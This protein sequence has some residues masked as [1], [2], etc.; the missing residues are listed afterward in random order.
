MAQVIWTE[1]ALNNL[2]AIADYIAVENPL[3]AAA[4]VQRVF[5]H[6]EQL[7]AHPESG[8]RVPELKRSRYRQIVEPPC[9]VLYRF[10][11]AKAF[12]LH[13]MRSEQL[14]RK[15]LLETRDL[16]RGL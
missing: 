8:P 15:G 14:L 7:E 12:I 4:L 11:G 10:D 3:A 6:I 5:G 16:E 9:R 1:P 2:D 13:V